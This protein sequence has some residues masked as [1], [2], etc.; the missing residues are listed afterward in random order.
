MN[1]KKSV[2]LLWT[3]LTKKCNTRGSWFLGNSC[4]SIRR[5]FCSHKCCPLQN[6]SNNITS[7]L[8]VS[9]TCTDDFQ[10]GFYKTFIIMP[11]VLC[12]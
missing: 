6:N 1:G 3:D 7:V 11:Q 8:G 9:A 12:F 4:S 10:C 5:S 2:Q